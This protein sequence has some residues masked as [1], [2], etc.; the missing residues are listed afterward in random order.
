MSEKVVILKDGVGNYFVL[1]VATL[2]Q[3][4][5]RSAEHIDLLDKILAD[6]KPQ[7]IGQLADL[8]LVSLGNLNVSEDRFLTLA[9]VPPEY[10]TKSM[11]MNPS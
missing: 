10:V 7:S 1:G 2:D 4:R 8:E 11:P 3:T 6:R 9:Y 5:V